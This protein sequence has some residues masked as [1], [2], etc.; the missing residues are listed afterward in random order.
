MRDTLRFQQ[1]VQQARIAARLGVPIRLL[2]MS[3]DNLSGA[4]F[5]ANINTPSDSAEWYEAALGHLDV[6]RD[7]VFEAASQAPGATVVEVDVAVDHGWKRAMHSVKWKKGDLAC[8]AF[9]R[10]SQF[11]RVFFSGPTSEFLRHCPAPSLIFPPS[12]A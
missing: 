7:N 3:P 6:A 9:R 10:Q 8:F 5:D 11:K 2:A 4:D 12:T 1:A